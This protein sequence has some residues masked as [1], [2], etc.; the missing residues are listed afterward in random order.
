MFERP[1]LVRDADAGSY[2]ES[3]LVWA[4]A[5]IL[6][7]R[8]YLALTGYPQLGGGLHIAHML[9]GGLLMLAALVLVLACL[10]KWAKRWAAG[11][12][13]VGFGTFIDELGKFVTRD[14]DYFFRPTIGILY[15]LLV[16]LF[17]LFRWIGRRRPLS[18]EEQL[19]N[20]ADLVRE[21]VLDGASREEVARALALLEG[22]ERAGLGGPV[23]A[24]IRA[25]VEGAARAPDRG[26]SLAGRAG[27]WG[28][29]AH[30][31]LLAWPPFHRALLALFVLEAAAGLAA[32]LLAGAAAAAVALTPATGAH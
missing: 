27:A 18:P 17:L 10:G 24:A 12:G 16:L 25:A 20:A 1:P 13:G 23:P 32:V 19:V 28:R 7:I 29:R 11:L 31:R 26:P 3:F 30:D 9:W 4:V 21:V 5:A 2:L 6:G 8:G 22:V 15:V 14:N